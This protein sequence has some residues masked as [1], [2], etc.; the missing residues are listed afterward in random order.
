[1]SGSATSPT[2]GTR[3]AI[4]HAL[5]AAAAPLN[6]AEVR[7][8][9]AKPV[10]PT[11][12]DTKQLLAS[13]VSAGEAHAWGSA[14]SPQFWSRKPAEA[15]PERILQALRDGPLSAAALA[16]RV[17][18]L[19]PGCAA[20]DVKPE[21]EAMAKGGKVR[22]H[23]PV[24]GKTPLYGLGPPDPSLYLGAVRK[25]MDAACAKLA[26]HGVP[27]DRVQQAL[28][29]MLGGKAGDA[30]PPATDL[31]AAI[32]AVVRIVSYRG[33]LAIPLLR[34]LLNRP[35]PEFD[36][37]VLDLKGKGLVILHAH[38]GPKALPAEERYELVDDG[39][40]T[41]YVGIGLR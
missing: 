22:T 4:R 29:E 37:A 23:P 32:L 30:T 16:K 18:A 19:L 38:D 41:C 25:A 5:Q 34:K 11:P 31:P 35:K 20:A 12:G 24:K 14:K 27:R 36:A 28:R 39:C 13:L 21:L 3:D 9:L 15:L 7:K 33:V 40:G 1:M 6:V 17:A 26:P 10:R 2:S 8:A